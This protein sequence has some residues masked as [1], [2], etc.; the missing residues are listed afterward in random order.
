METHSNEVD[1]LIEMMTSRFLDD[2]QQHYSFID[3]ERGYMLVQSG[4]EELRVPLM[5]LAIGHVSTRTHRFSDIREITEVAAENRRR[6]DSSE[7]SN[8]DD[9]FTLSSTSCQ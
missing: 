4:G 2:I 7:S 1:D 6:G 5:S 9:I 8:S 3:R